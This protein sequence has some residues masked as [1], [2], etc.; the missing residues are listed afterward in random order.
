MAIIDGFQLN[1]N[2]V[3]MTKLYS[4]YEAIK[5]GIRYKARIFQIKVVT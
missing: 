2:P 3:E 1:L 5:E 4:T